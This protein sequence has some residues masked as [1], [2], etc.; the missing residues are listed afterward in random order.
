MLLCRTGRSDRS[1]RRGVHSYW[2]IAGCRP[3]SV[4]KCQRSPTQQPVDARHG[5][6]DVSWDVSASNVKEG[7]EKAHHGEANSNLTRLKLLRTSDS[8][9]P[10]GLVP[11][12]SL[13]TSNCPSWMRPPPAEPE[14][15]A[16]N[17]VLV[18]ADDLG[19]VDP[20]IQGHPLIRTPDIDRPARQGQR[21]TSFYAS[22][23]CNPS[24]VALVTG[25]LPDSH[26]PARPQ[27][28]GG[29]S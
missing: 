17:F 23:P 22:A 24:R 12:A 27:P 20:S 15:R 6:D 19:Y 2:S 10:L 3:R 28:V 9:S 4:A 18:L 21:W 11:H 16:P 29:S 5:T 13:R 14:I 26:P 1:V 8:P 25:R 7:I